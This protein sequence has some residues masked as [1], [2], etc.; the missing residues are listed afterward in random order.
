MTVD[1]MELILGL[2]ERKKQRI[3]VNEA[4]DIEGDRLGKVGPWNLWLPTTREKSCKIAQY[5]PVTMVPKTTWCTARTSGSNLF[6]SYV[7]RLG[8]DITLFY[9]I[10]DSPESDVDWVSIGFMNGKPT[11][12]GKNGG[13]SVDRANKGL[14]QTRLRDILGP[15]HDEIMVIF[16]E[17]NRSLGGRHPARDKVQLAARNIE[18]FNHV[19]QGVSKDEASDLMY[20]IMREPNVN[21][22]VLKLMLDRGNAGVRSQIVNVSKL[23]LSDEMLDRVV[24][25]PDA[26]V[27][28][29]ILHYF[30]KRREAVPAWLALKLWN[31]PDNNTKYMI[32][33]HPSIPKESITAFFEDLSRSKNKDDR[34]RA[35]NSIRDHVI[36]AKLASDRVDEIRDAVAAN[37]HTPPD[38]LVKLSND[39]KERVYMSAIANENMPQEMLVSFS[40]DPDPIKRR[41]VA[42]NPSTPP[43]ILSKLARDDEAQV[44]RWVAKHPNTTTEVVRSMLN[45]TDINTVINAKEELKKRQQ[46]MNEST[47]RRLIRQ[48]L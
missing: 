32:A 9:A 34:D 26:G 43:A 36:L 16:K 2:S 17:K 6:Y 44:R 40:S 11:L 18:D 28:R 13:L 35:A 12:D 21:D 41:S 25:D 45:D 23:K 24:S 1:E 42:W 4:E 30:E 27:R 15:Y 38:V 5:D 19:T 22:D 31:D 8:Q 47:L 46:S 10:K 7:G 37:L 20:L 33:T 14:T 29:A 39:K 3:E 48:M